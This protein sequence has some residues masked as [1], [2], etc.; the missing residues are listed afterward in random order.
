LMALR[1]SVLLRIS[2][3]TFLMSQWM[4]TPW[5][6]YHHTHLPMSKLPTQLLLHSQSTPLRFL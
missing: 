5:T 6:L 3:T 4:G 2:A 1:L